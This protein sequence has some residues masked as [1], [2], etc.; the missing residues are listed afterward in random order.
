MISVIVP[1][2]NSEQWLERCARSL[3]EQGGDFEFLL[4]DDHSTD[5]GPKIAEEYAAK[6]ER[7]VLLTNERGKG[8]SGARNTGIDHARGAWTTFLD[9]DDE[10]RPGAYGKFAT[11]A[12]TGANICQLNHLRCYERSGRTVLR[13]ANNGG[14]Y[15][16]DCLPDA[17]WGVWNKLF[18]T[19][20]IKWI[21]FN[22]GLKCGED[23]MFVL[24][25]LREDGRIHHAD[26]SV[27]VVVHR[28]DN[29][30]SLSHVKTAGDIIEQ[31][32]AYED[33]M[34]MQEDIA[35]KRVVCLEL[36]KL[37]E[38]VSRRLV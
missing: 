38:R 4:V 14:D 19:D 33:F 12:K 31:I 9:A 5:S 16:L 17:W 15:G 29:Q 32:Q 7:F 28:F 30:G 6:D 11:V 18:K 23:G 27:T 34:T 8:V 26:R 20:F 13:Y 37:W 24:E 10:Y 25:C 2:W 36:S 35:L 1:Y 22:E 21:R 3:H